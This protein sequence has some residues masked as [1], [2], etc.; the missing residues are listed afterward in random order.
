MS[1][2][3]NGFAS[4]RPE[5]CRCRW[6]SAAHVQSR[7]RFDERN[8]L[9]VI[10]NPPRS[11]LRPTGTPYYI[12][13]TTH[14]IQTNAILDFDKRPTAPVYVLVSHGANGY[15]AYNVNTGARGTLP[16]N[17]TTGEKANAGGIN[18]QTFYEVAKIDRT[19]TNQEQGFDDVVA[20]ADA[21]FDLRQSGAE[22]RR[23]M[24]FI[25]HQQGFTLVEL[26]IAIL[27]S[28][29][30]MAGGI[31]L[32]DRAQDQLR[33]QTTYDHIDAITSALSI[34]AESS[35]RLP[36]PTDPTVN[37][38]RFGWEAGCPDRCRHDSRQSGSR[39]RRFSGRHLRIRQHWPVLSVLCRSCS[40]NLDDATARDG[41]GRYFTYA[42][43]PQF[44]R[45]NDQSHN[46]DGT[47]F[48][49][50]KRSDYGTVHGRCRTAGWQLGTG[51]QININALKARFC[52]DD[53]RHGWKRC[54][55]C[56]VQFKGL[57]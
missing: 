39:R 57:R 29:L 5:Y 6:Q 47:S 23:T 34:F 16:G 14:E 56:S 30:I 44:A 1:L 4:D 12:N 52:C 33:L 17:L 36:C 38:Q 46:V 22:L 21:G 20:L 8:C 27:C 32:Y 15:G 31:A 54:Q 43:S 24:T 50:T 7:Y 45:R 10:S 40:L 3:N 25:R 37:D 26:A 28:G 53:K 49:T 2:S 9:C 13:T 55:S 19:S 42:V 11:Q 41:W 35:D 51:N 18:A 48:G